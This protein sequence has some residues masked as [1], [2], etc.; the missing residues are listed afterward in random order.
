M[1]AP[2]ILLYDNDCPF[3]TWYTNVFI[4]MH[5][6]TENGRVSFTQFHQTPDIKLDSQLAQNKIACINPTTHEITYGIDSLLLLLG[7]RFKWI[8]RVG[9]WTIIHFLLE[10]LYAL[11]SFNRKIIAPTRKKSID[12][13]CEPGKSTFWRTSFILVLSILTSFMVNAFFNRF[14]VAYLVPAPV[15]DFLL[16]LLQ[17]GIQ[18]LSFKLL[19]QRNLYDYLGH[20]A[21]VSFLGSLFLFALQWTLL[22]IGR[23]GID[24]SLLATSGYGMVLL[25]MFLEHKR[26]LQLRE[27]HWVLSISWILFR[28]LIYPLVFHS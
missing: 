28:C 21:F 3:C 13:S 17:L 8:E 15:N 10:G 18:A 19:K 4:R 5:L 11:I 24:C 14:L 22:L 26:R 16:L 12:C 27:W 6:L 9:K 7:Q 23:F 25:W 1:K 20:V 2:F